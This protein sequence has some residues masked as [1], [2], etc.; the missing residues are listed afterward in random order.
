MSEKG[1]PDF[2]VNPPKGPRSNVILPFGGKY[3]RPK[4]PS[5]RH[6]Q[7]GRPSPRQVQVSM[8]PEGIQIYFKTFRSIWCP[9]YTLKSTAIPGLNVQAPN[10]P[11]TKEQHQKSTPGQQL[12]AQAPPF[13][14]GQS[15]IRNGEGAVQ[16]T[17]LSKL[18]PFIPASTG[19]TADYLHTTIN[20]RSGLPQISCPYHNTPHDLTDMENL[21]NNPTCLH[22]ALLSHIQSRIAQVGDDLAQIMNASTIN[23]QIAQ[24]H[25]EKTRAFY[26]NGQQQRGVHSSPP[27]ARICPSN[28]DLYPPWLKEIIVAACREPR[29]GKMVEAFNP[30]R[31]PLTMMKNGRKRTMSLPPM[32]RIE[33]DDSEEHLAVST[34]TPRRSIKESGKEKAPSRVLLK[35]KTK[36]KKERHHSFRV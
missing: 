12:N 18:P 35:S 30:E 10:W 5:S 4:D 33:D 15:L 24:S 20:L 23:S 6:D 26:F 16:P 36:K 14:P 32:P 8:Q 9:P 7:N 21:A 3:L 19:L 28:Q 2:K 25:W 34:Q 11:P 13:H 27:P 22:K 17:S 1:S 29:H 31:V